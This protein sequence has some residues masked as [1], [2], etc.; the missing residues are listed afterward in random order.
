M[1]EGLIYWI[2]LR[3]HTPAASP[4]G[5]LLLRVFG[6]A[7]GVYRASREQLERVDITKFRY[8]N[9]LYGRI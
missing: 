8:L 7:E 3:T 2:W 9:N 4:I 1:D 6:D 5:R